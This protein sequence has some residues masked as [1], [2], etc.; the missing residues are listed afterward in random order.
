MGTREP[1]DPVRFLGNRLRPAGHRGGA[2]RGAAGAD[3]HLIAANVEPALLAGLGGCRDRRLDRGRAGIAVRAADGDVVLAAAAVADYRPVAAAGHKLKKAGG[4]RA[5]A[6]TRATPDILAA[7]PWRR[8]GQ[9]IVG[10]AAETGDDAGSARRHAEAKARR[11]GADLLVFNEV[12]ETRGFGDV[13]ND[14]VI[15]DAGGAEVARAAGTKAEVARAVVETVVGL[16]AR[17][18]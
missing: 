8:P 14:V 17:L 9:V 12:S 6:D 1:L 10:F 3:V 11:K 5:R 4:R 16:R 7:C 13:P 2:R 18:G 15:L